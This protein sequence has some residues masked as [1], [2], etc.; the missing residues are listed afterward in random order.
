MLRFCK[1]LDEGKIMNYFYVHMPV[2][3]VTDQVESINS[4]L[5]MKISITMGTL[6]GAN[7]KHTYLHI[8]TFFYI[9]PPKYV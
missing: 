1:K 2:L 7:P 4:F 6:N 5:I 8:N 9:F 3:Y